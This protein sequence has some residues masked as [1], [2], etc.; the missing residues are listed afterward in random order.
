MD[1]QKAKLAEYQYSK[2]IDV[3]ASQLAAAE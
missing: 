2:N 3:S 1:N